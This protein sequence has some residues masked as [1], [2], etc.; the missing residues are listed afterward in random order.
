[1]ITHFPKIIMIRK[2]V[3]TNNNIQL[4]NY[5]ICIINVTINSN[6]FH[7]CT[8]HFHFQNAFLPRM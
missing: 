3:L 4:V 5:N 7:R 6:D 1:M 8:I 2:V